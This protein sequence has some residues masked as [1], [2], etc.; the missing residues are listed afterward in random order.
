MGIRA[1]SIGRNSLTIVALGLLGA[2]GGGSGGL[3]ESL[4]DPSQMFSW[5]TEQKVIGF[6]H[7]SSLFS[8]EP[9]RKGSSTFPL[10]QAS[11][12]VKAIASAVT[13]QYG[14]NSNGTPKTGNTIDDYMLDNKVTGL[15]VIKNGSIALERY[16]MGITDSTLW[17]G[18]SVSKSVTSTLMGAALKDGYITSLSDP[19]E[20]YIPELIG[21]AYQGV[22]LRDMLRM[23]SGIAWNENELD[24]NADLPNLLKCMKT[25]DSPTCT[26]NYMKARPRAIDPA[27]GSPVQPGTVFLY[28]TGEAYLSGLVVQRATGMSLAEYMEKRI[29]QPLG[30]EADGNWWTWNG[31]STGGSGFN[32]TLRDYGRFGQFILNNGVLPNGVQVLPDN[33]MR[34]AT[35]WTSASAQPQYADNG[36]YGYMWWFSPAYDDGLV[37]GTNN[38]DPIYVDIGAP[39]QNTNS[40]SGAVAVQSRPPVQGQPA[41]VSDWTFAAIGIYGQMIAIN[42][43][44][45][46]V[47]VEFGVWDKPDP[48]CCTVSDSEYIASDP[49]NEQSVFLN[50]M[51]RALH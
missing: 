13:Y 1:I 19:I 30:M 45:N 14:T 42:Q 25:A 51:L 32:A 28:S 31:T 41:S 21:S 37:G 2:C 5:T 17:D 4:P 35:T 18:K 46:L 20:K 10:N 23:S 11:N 40:P 3:S 39:L 38:P 26:L 16:A 33:W 47:V 6:S 12:D 15:L 34:D 22:T 48:T 50:A 36:Q 9:I 43:R 27:T 29:W 49:Y 24:P 44:E 7:S 8:T